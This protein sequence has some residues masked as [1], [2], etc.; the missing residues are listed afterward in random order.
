MLAGAQQLAVACRFGDAAVA[1]PH[2]FLLR[3]LVHGPPLPSAR[4]AGRRGAGCR[5]LRSLRAR[6]RSARSSGFADLF[7][8]C[9]RAL[10][11]H[12]AFAIGVEGLPRH[13]LRIGDP[14]LVGFGVAAGRVLGLD[15]R[16]L[17]AAEPVIHFRE[18]GLVFGLDA[19]MR[20]AGGA[21]R[22][23]C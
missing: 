20:D 19:E 21:A 4:A 17:G 9:E 13:A 23:A 5:R 6:S 10:A 3:V 1:R 7:Q 14:L 15:D 8:L 2:Q 12:R 16:P 11:I 18:L 22:A